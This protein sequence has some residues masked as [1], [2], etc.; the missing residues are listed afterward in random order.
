[1]KPAISNI[2]LPPYKHNNELLALR[3]IGFEGLE[4]AVTRVWE[5]SDRISFSQVE[6][7]R[8]QVEN[9]GLKILGL[10]SL[11]F[12]KPGLGLFRENSVRGKTLN[13]LTYLSKVC[14]D[15]GGKTLVYGSPSARK[16]NGLSVDQ[17][18]KQ[19]ISF[20]QDLSQ[21]IE[22]HDTCFV[23]EALGKDETDYIHSALHALRI[24]RAVDREQLKCHLDAKAVVDADE[25]R[26]EVF[27]E[28]YPRLVHFHAND[29]GLGILGETS[30]VNHSLLGKLLRKIDYKGYISIEQKM[31]DTNYPL[32]PIQKSYEV[33]KGSYL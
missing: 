13:F 25:D 17:A 20:F 6:N 32:A 27:K 2:A 8:H 28:V 19:T 29:P 1:L 16:K 11:F 33:F 10:H 14:V 15:L 26:I 31:L 5:K 12:D 30:K 7:Y 18:D 22:L 21:K 23:L 3:D 4:V 9:A 24:S